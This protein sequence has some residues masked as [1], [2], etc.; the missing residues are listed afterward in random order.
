MLVQLGKFLKSFFE[1]F[2]EKYQ[3]Q[4]SVIVSLQTFCFREM[5]KVRQSFS[6][7]V[8][9]GVKLYWEKHGIYE[10]RNRMEEDK[11]FN[12]FSCL[13]F[14]FA[15]LPGFWLVSRHQ[16]WPLIGREGSLG[17]SHWWAGQS[18]QGTF[19]LVA[20]M[21]GGQRTLSTQSDN[22][23]S[24]MLKGL[25][26]FA[27]ILAILC[28]CRISHRIFLPVSPLRSFLFHGTSLSFLSFRL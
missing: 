14:R 16:Y 2:L 1:G 6:K 25:T 27:F 8:L 23:P 22:W 21:S 20:K 26:L 3:K 24:I 5:R 17:A 18:K 10:N 11:V 13:V 9:W 28:P 12:P 4:I 7:F 19:V 15:T